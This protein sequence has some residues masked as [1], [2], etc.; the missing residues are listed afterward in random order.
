[1]CIRDRYIVAI[2]FIRE[3]L[4][5]M[6]ITYRLPEVLAIVADGDRYAAVTLGQM[7][8]VGT[9]NQLELI[10]MNRQCPGGCLPSMDRDHRSADRT[11]LL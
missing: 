11:C 8:I 9:I 5:T 2:L 3:P 1:M 4:S 10:I 7:S 6:A